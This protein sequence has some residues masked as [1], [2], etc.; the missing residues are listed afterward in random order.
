MVNSI[1]RKKFT[2]LQSPMDSAERGGE[3]LLSGEHSSMS[4]DV[5]SSRLSNTQT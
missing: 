5:Y 3:L 1:L 4:C 2:G